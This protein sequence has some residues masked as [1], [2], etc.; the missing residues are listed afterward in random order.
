MTGALVL[1]S[2]S[3]A[4]AG[5]GLVTLGLDDGLRPLVAPAVP[6]FQVRPPQE[7]LPLAARYDALVVGPGWGRT[8]DR[9]GLLANLW[10]LPLPLVLDADGLTAWGTLSPGPRKAPTVITPHPGEFRRLG[11]PGD[12]P[13]DAAGR[14]ARDRGVTVVLKGAVTWILDPEGRRAVWDRANPTLGTGGSGD[15]LAGV[16]G[17]FLARGWDGFD[18]A[19]A[20][21][22]LHA[23]A[24]RRLAD[25]EGWFTADRLPRALAKVSAACRTTAGRL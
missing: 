17:A 12:N 11:A 5:A 4:A 18:A 22:V 1:A 13:V 19:C 3:A 16:V 20:A 23:E 15:C 8:D 7:L 9:P 25:A 2:R 21:V 6:A 10:D 24:G 14:L